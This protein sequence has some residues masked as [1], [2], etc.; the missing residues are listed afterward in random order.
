MYYSNDLSMLELNYAGYLLSRFTLDI[1]SINEKCQPNVFRK[2][3]F[4]HKY[5]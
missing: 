5:D 4:F 1:Y 2:L 3:F